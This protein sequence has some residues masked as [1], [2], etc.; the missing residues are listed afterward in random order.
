M[1]QNYSDAIKCL[2]DQGFG[3]VAELFEAQQADLHAYQRANDDAHDALVKLV[4]DRP[5]LNFLLGK[6][7]TTLEPEKADSVHT[8]KHS[9]ET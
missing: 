6:I 7:I 1:P 5:S 8:P 3:A 2:E 4:E 9:L